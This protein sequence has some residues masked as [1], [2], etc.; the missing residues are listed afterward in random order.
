[1]PGLSE[2]CAS[3]HDFRAFLLQLQNIQ[4]LSLVIGNFRLSPA[5]FNF[6]PIRFPNLEYLGASVTSSS[7]FS[8]FETPLL[9]EVWL[10]CEKSRSHHGS[11]S[12]EEISSLIDRSS[13]RIRYLSL[14]CC[15]DEAARK[16][17]K[18]LS[19]VEDFD[20]E[21]RGLLSHLVR[22]IA[23]AKEYIYLPKMRV[24]E[25]KSCPR[26]F[27][28]VIENLYRLL[29]ARGKESGI[30]PS[31][32]NFVPLERLMIRVDWVECD[33][34]S[35]FFALTCNNGRRC[36]D[37][38]LLDMFS[39]PSFSVTDVRSD[40]SNDGSITMKARALA[41]GTQIELTFYYPEGLGNSIYGNE[42]YHRI[43]EHS[44]LQELQ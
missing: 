17:I 44:L 20:T 2:S 19:S 34:C 18:T 4:E 5:T 40:K 15:C 6:S 9:V 32:R 21:E 10:F 13:C 35:V 26:R 8:W 23:N 3:G 42:R 43:L 36:F 37:R 7:I 22:D 31:S 28:E 38:A 12:T 16:I 41:A 27:I 33:C 14:Q 24:F 29:E 1:M 11:T 39:W 30:A 25:V